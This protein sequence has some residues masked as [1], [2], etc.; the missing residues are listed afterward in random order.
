MLKKQHHNRLYRPFD[1]RK[2]FFKSTTYLLWTKDRNKLIM[3]AS[4]EVT[5]KASIKI[6]YNT[7]YIFAI[8]FLFYYEITN[9][10]GQTQIRNLEKEYYFYKNKNFENL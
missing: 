9:I 7:G 4:D 3:T 6:K 1:G 2:H 10:T 5:F 8:K